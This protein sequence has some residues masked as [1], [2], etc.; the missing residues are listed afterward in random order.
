MNRSPWGV[1]VER[2]SVALELL[3]VGLA[4][5]GGRLPFPASCWFQGVHQTGVRSPNSVTSIGRYAF[6]YNQLTSVTI[7]SSVTS[8]G[9]GA[10]RGN[11]GINCRVPNSAP[12]N[13]HSPNI[14]CST[15][16]RY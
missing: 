11:T 3:G 12:Y 5:H 13:P 6:M 7:P 4:W 16:E 14:N 15:I 10:F 2:D 9:S 1:L 8:I